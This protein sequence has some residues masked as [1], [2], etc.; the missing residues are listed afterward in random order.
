[1]LKNIATISW[2][3]SQQI[4]ERLLIVGDSIV[5]NIEPYKMKKSTKYVTKVKLIPGATTEGMVH[6][7][8]GCVVDFAPDNVLLQCGIN[9]FKKYLTPQKIAQNILKLAEEVSDG[10]NSRFLELLIELM[11]LMLKCKK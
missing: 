11:I 8:K 6:H 3:Q 5:K 9:D 10:G 1:M 4:T 2:Q 7:V